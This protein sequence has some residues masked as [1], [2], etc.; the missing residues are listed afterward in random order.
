MYSIQG[1]LFWLCSNA[2]QEF[3]TRLFWEDQQ[4]GHQLHN[5]HD[6]VVRCKV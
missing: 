6:K 5:V 4:V 2:Y 3:R 1:F